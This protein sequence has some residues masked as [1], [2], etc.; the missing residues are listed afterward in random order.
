MLHKSPLWKQKTFKLYFKF[1]IIHKNILIS[2][3][4]S[5]VGWWLERGRE[6]T[7]IKKYNFKLLVV[8]MQLKPH[9]F[10]KIWVQCTK[11]KRDGA[12]VM[13]SC[14]PSWIFWCLPLEDST[15]SRYLWYACSYIA[16]F[17]K[18]LLEMSFTYIGW[19]YW[20]LTFLWTAPPD[21]FS[22]MA[23]LFLFCVCVWGLRLDILTDF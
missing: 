7:N 13:Q 11:I 3:Y 19:T 17:W 4:Q 10:F 8:I 16:E 18:S 22:R 21:I 23:L 5:W 12:S 14:L 15:V 1:C 9:P 6:A 2:L 20:A